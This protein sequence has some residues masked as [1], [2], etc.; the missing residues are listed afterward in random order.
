MEVHSAEANSV[1]LPPLV[2]DRADI[3]MGDETSLF[4][5]LII[6]SSGS[7]GHVGS[8][9]YKGSL[10]RVDMTGHSLSPGL[11]DLMLC[12]AFGLSILKDDLLEVARRYLRLGVTSCQFT[13][14]SIEWPGLTRIAHRVF[15][16]MQASEKRTD[17]ARVLGVYFEGPF[18]HPG[19]AGAAKSSMCVPA[20]SQNVKQAINDFGNS[21]P[22]IT[23]SPGIEGDAQAIRRLADAGKIV[24]LSHSAAPADRV[25]G[26]L[27]AGATVVG[28]IWNNNGGA[29]IEP[30]V[31]QPTLDT[32]AL[33]D[34]RVRWLHLICD[35]AHVH[36]VFVQLAQR[37]RGDSICLVSDAQPVAEMP[38]GFGF[39]LDD[40]QQI[41]R[42]GSAARGEGDGALFGSGCLLPQHFRNYVR[43]TGLPPSLAIRTVT[44][45]PARS[46]GLE[47]QVGLIAKGRAADLVAWDGQ[48]CVK[49]V[50]RSGRAVL[51]S[52][53]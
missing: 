8:G 37:C 23:V 13:S 24:T 4:G 44:F 43:F 47:N 41:R 49:Q 11:I 48:L 22:M 36:P 50:W 5:H 19:A 16:A 25:F 14:G 28:H 35:G 45:N 18:K 12:G 31:Q 7:I 30:G 27:D 29:L 9:P 42:V 46:M 20:T 51:G 53:A 6:D 2:L 38:E 17:V 15:D 21:V 32:V 33:F 34:Q 52:N 10:P 40:G 3:W 26:C 1:V 39:V